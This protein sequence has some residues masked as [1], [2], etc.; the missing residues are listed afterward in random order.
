MK[1]IFEIDLTN[2]NYYEIN[3]GWVNYNNG[4]NETQCKNLCLNDSTCVFVIHFYRGQVNN[5]D[6]STYDRKP[7][8]N[9]PNNT[10]TSSATNSQTIKQEFDIILGQSN[11]FQLN[12]Q[13]Q[14]GGKI[15]Q[16]FD[17]SILLFV[18]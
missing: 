16:T 2:P 14:Y 12:Y 13:T 1:L 17:Q 4:S 6:S 5:S 9:A 11:S 15:N 18:N 10:C 8:K 7:L 3:D